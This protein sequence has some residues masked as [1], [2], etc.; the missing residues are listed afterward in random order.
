MPAILLNGE[1][2]VEQKKPK[3]KEKNKMKF[4][5]RQAFCGGYPAE[6]SVGFKDHPTHGKHDLTKVSMTVSGG[7][8]FAVKISK[9]DKDELKY[10]DLGRTLGDDTTFEISAHGALE[11]EALL[12]F[13]KFA[14]TVLETKDQQLLEALCHSEPTVLE[15]KDQQ[16]LEALCHSEPEE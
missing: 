1:S 11:R 15:A 10:G 3:K 6:M 8:I 4:Y 16:L 7:M 13:F 2:T 12:K 9:E 5:S 14:I